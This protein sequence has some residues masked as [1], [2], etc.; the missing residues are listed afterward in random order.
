VR[1]LDVGGWTDTWFARQG[2][3]CHLAVGPGAEA[4]ASMSPRGA[5][6][7]SGS[8]DVSLHVPAFDDHYRFS[9]DAPP[10]RHPLLEATLCRWAPRGCALEATVTSEVPAGSSLGTSASVVVALVAALNELA[11]R[12]LGAE[13]LAHAA[14]DVETV[15]LGRQSGVQDQVAAAFGGL[16]LVR[17]DPY[18]KF[19]VSAVKLADGASEALGR[20][21]VTAYLGAFHDSSAIH[22]AVIK[23]LTTDGHDPDQLLE[24]L[25][26]A[27]GKAAGA[28]VAGDLA[29]YGEA[30]I[31]CTEAQAALHPSLVNPLAWQVIEVAAR[32]GALGWKVN[33]AGGTGGTVSVVGPEDLAG[34]RYGLEAV[35]GVTVLDL[36][37]ETEGAHVVERG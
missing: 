29:A 22:E 28:L 14:H 9:L 21:V 1:V 23:R 4:F 10:G 31:S 26:V 27:A 24:P 17:I 16:N 35:D 15:D 5:P 2:A 25:R 6:G 34:L 19:H 20:R 30:L 13:A 36:R 33:G 8:T 32:F 11:G 18:P 37:P 12:S 7:Q 3:V